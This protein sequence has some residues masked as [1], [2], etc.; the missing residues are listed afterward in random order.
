MPT[1]GFGHFR[2]RLEAAIGA[3]APENQSAPKVTLLVS[4]VISRKVIFADMGGAA[5]R[6]AGTSFTGY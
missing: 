2:P 4:R 3:R 1:R 6:E 5:F